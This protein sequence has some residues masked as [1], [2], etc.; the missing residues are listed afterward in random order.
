MTISRWQ[1]LNL[2]MNLLL[3]TC[4]L[5]FGALGF[6]PGALC[7]PHA[8]AWHKSR[9]YCY[10]IPSMLV[11]LPRY[12]SLIFP[13]IVFLSRSSRHCR[14]RCAPGSPTPPRSCRPRNPRGLP[15][16]G[17]ATRMSSGWTPAQPLPW[18]GRDCSRLAEKPLG[19]PTHAP[20]AWLG[21]APLS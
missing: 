5:C 19:P 15:P 14:C 20:W 11:D 3:L 17:F 21:F 9:D 8:L 10:C 18:L 6:R 13:L 7:H 2:N 4:L 12:F 16:L 1:S